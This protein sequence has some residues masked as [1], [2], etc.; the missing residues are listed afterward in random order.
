MSE[1]FLEY[2][3]PIEADDNEYILL[4]P[5]KYEFTVSDVYYD[6]HQPGPN[7]LG[8]IPANTK[9]VILS[10]S[11]DA[12]EGTVIVK[13]TFFLHPSTSWRVTSIHKCL[14]IIP[15]DY[16]GIFNMDWGSMVGKSGWV[17]TKLESGAN[18]PDLK[19]N[20]VDTY[21]K[22]SQVTTNYSAL[23]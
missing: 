17:K 12:P 4:E 13:D 22:P 19:Y 1:Q 10:L 21:I 16:K 15:E 23:F 6:I 8:K 9:K 14:G 11:I 5:G 3:A 7:S 20:K 18:N 2:N